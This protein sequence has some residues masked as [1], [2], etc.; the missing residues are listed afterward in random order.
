MPTATKKKRTRARRKGRRERP[1]AKRRVQGRPGLPGWGDLAGPDQN[2]KKR[3]ASFLARLTTARYALLVLA[4]AGACALYVGHVHATQALLSEV[5]RARIENR[6]L[7]LKKNRLQSAFNEATAP[8]VI[9]RR[10]GKLG[11]EGGLARGP[12]IYV[13]GGE[14]ATDD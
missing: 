1:Q 10:A 11:L 2:E 7:H 6:R 8:A 4:V 13:G 9:Y 12:A 14:G 5:E 3:A